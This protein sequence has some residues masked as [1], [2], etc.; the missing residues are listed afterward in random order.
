MN[1]RVLTVVLLGELAKTPDFAFRDYQFVDGKCVLQGTEAEV[2]ARFHYL[3]V[4]LDTIGI[5]GEVEDAPTAPNAEGNADSTAHPDNRLAEALNHLDPADDE[6]WT[7]AGKP[8]LEAV[9][10]FYGSSSVTR[11]DI[12]A[13]RPGWGR[14]DARAERAPREPSAPEPGAPEKGAPEAP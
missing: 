9:E 6:H 3:K 11:K 8:A 5:E 14:E 1:M 7:Q 13:A 12:E 2:Q 4:N 10:R